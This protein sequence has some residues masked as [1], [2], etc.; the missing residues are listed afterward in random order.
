MKAVVIHEPGGP[1]VLKIETL[2]R[3][4]PAAGEVPIRV[5][6]FGLNR[7]ELFTRPQEH[8]P[9]VRFPSEKFLYFQQRSKPFCLNPANRNFRLLF[10]VHFQLEAG[11]KPGNDFLNPVDINKKRSVY[12]PE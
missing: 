9:S 1:E 2:P 5:K 11:L 3:P 8:S 4:E 6:A 10:V 12:S 7:S